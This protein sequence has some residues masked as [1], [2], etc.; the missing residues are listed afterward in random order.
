MET[1]LR[2]FRVLFVGNVF[3]RILAGYRFTDE[4]DHI[5]VVWSKRHGY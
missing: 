4:V 2:M 5:W 1:M 3:C